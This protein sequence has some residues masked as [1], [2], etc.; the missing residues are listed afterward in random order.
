MET[1][2]CWL[3]TQIDMHGWRQA[4]LA[5][6]AGIQPATLN[7]I[8]NGTRNMGPEVAGQIA[9]ALGIPPEEVLRRAGLLP[10]VTPRRAEDEEMDHILGR[11]DERTRQTILTMLRGL[12]PARPALNQQRGAY[13]TL[14]ADVRELAEIYEELDPIWRPELMNAARAMAINA[15]GGAPRIIGGDDA[16]PESD[17]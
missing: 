2:G 17:D 10:P 13:D 5:R 9:K 12:T 15:R 11:L 1:L 4:E 6:R 3:Q 14:P 7:R 8:I 16:A